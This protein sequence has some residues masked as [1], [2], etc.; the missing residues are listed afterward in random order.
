MLTD[1]KI[2]TILPSNAAKI[3]SRIH[4]ARSRTRPIPAPQPQPPNDPIPLRCSGWMDGDRPRLRLSHVTTTIL[5]FVCVHVRWQWITVVALECERC[6]RGDVLAFLAPGRH[7]A[8]A[9]VFVT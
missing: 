4:M 9:C 8:R 5:P 1:Y 7:K 6:P 2:R 3:A